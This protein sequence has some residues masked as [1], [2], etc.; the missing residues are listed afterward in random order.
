MEMV[1][2]PPASGLTSASPAAQRPALRHTCRHGIIMRFQAA[3]IYTCF[4]AAP[5]PGSRSV[6]AVCGYRVP[7]DGA[8]AYVRPGWIRL[9]RRVQLVCA[10]QAV[11]RTVSVAVRVPN[12]CH[13]PRRRP[14]SCEFSRL[15]G[16]I[17]MSRR[18][19]PCRAVGCGVHGRMADGIRACRAVG[20]TVGVPRTATDGHGRTAMEAARRSASR[21]CSPAQ[22]EST[23]T[24]RHGAV[25]SGAVQYSR[26]LSSSSPS[27][28]Q[29]NGSAP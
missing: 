29:L 25:R 11:L 2:R 24:R 23:G 14:V 3:A 10:G 20:V 13:H 6:D 4:A 1:L 17:F 8:S 16:R 18:V 27:R 22:P 9:G 12:T 21:W 15:A 26:H 28:R 19:S 7:A 5:F